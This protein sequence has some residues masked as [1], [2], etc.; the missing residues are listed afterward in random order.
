M[1]SMKIVIAG[2]A[3]VGKS[4]VAKAIAEKFDCNHIS[5][6]DIFRNK[7]RVLG[8]SVHE[9][10]ELARKDFK[11][12]SDLDQ[13]VEKYGLTNEKFV[14]DSRL[15]WYFIPDAVKI[16]MKCDAPVRIKRIA[17]R[18]GKPFDQVEKETLEREKAIEERYR[19][20]YKIEKFDDEKA[21]DLVVDTTKSSV[22]ESTALIL[23][24]LEKHKPA[25]EKD[26]VYNT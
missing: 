16:L 24:F 25:P 1:P 17:E 9:L 3:G 8:L 20:Y 15:A 2:L 12:D 21:F 19:K 11:Y 26:P 10:D 22:E 14:I 5:S 23:D 13:E 18:E 7:A 6:G 4:S